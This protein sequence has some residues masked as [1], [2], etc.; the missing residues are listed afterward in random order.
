MKKRNLS[1][2]LLRMICSMFVILLH[3]IMA[4]RVIDGKVILDVLF[5]EG[6]VRCCIPIFLMITGFF[7]FKSKKTTPEIL[8]NVFFT[9]VIPTIA[10]LM[11]LQIFDNFIE[12]RTSFIDCLIHF[13]IDW[14]DLLS[15]LVKFSSGSK[16]GYYLWYVFTLIYFYLWFP[17][18]RYI[19][20]DNKEQ[21]LIRRL[22]MLLAFISHVLLPSI[23]AVFPQLTDIV[24]VPSVLP[25]HFLLYNLIGFEFSVFYDKYPTFFKKGFIAFSSALI[26]LA[27]TL[28]SFALAVN[29][30]ANIH[31]PFY[32]IF[33]GYE[34]F[35][36][37]TQ[38]L[39]LF[40]LFLSIDQFGILEGKTSKF[41]SF[42][43]DKM[44]YVYL[45]HWPFIL[46]HVRTGFPDYL[47][48]TYGTF[49]VLGFVL[50]SIIMCFL[51]GAL[52]DFVIKKIKLLLL[53]KQ[54]Q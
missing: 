16:N 11:L 5:I 10:T 50:Y 19:C 43:G 48:D 39:G 49:A 35:L 20:V 42:F 25:D 38:A 22:I 23:Y 37:L 13:N 30:D 4:Y 26:Y 47:N 27:S 34:M 14:R 41:I 52:V 15:H 44:F 7:V 17:L 29:F 28:I 54:D 6:F 3:V 21:N 40:S 1:I 12:N 18:L 8:K 51:I 33:Y 46:K 53:K 24:H 9:I 31:V 45:V 2:D 36:I 32:G